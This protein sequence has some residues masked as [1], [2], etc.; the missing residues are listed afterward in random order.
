[1]RATTTFI[2]LII[3]AAL[4]LWAGCSQRIQLVKAR[5]LD[6]PQ[7]MDQRD[8]REPH[9]SSSYDRLIEDGLV[10]YRRADLKGARRLFER[11]TAIDSTYWLGHYYLGLA[12]TDA[13]EHAQ[14]RADLLSSL[15]YAPRDKRIRSLIYVA[16]AECWESQGNMGQARLNF[17]T[18]LNLDPASAPATQGLE[19]V[20]PPAQ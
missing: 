18:A 4:G 13:G 10:L 2:S 7:E 5:R 11:A 3:A 9:A 12:L 14:A 16:L 8:E 19:R 17:L 20:T 1:M 6:P 15:D